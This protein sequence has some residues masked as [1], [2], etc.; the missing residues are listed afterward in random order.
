MANEENKIRMM[1]CPSSQLSLSKNVFGELVSP[2][3]SH[4]LSTYWISVLL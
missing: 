2:Q 1:I 3:V 4:R